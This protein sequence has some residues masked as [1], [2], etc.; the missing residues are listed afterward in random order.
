M[1]WRSAAA[2]CRVM[3]SA[4]GEIRALRIALGVE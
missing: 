4:V 1:L 3:F 2:R